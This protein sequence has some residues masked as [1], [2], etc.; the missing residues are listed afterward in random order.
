[1]L[2]TAVVMSL[3]SEPV[4]SHHVSFEQMDTGRGSFAKS[5]SEGVALAHDGHP[6]IVDGKETQDTVAAENIVM[7][8]EINIG[9]SIT[10]DVKATAAGKIEDELNWSALLIASGKTLG[11][12]T[13]GAVAAKLPQGSLSKSNVPI[14][15]QME[16]SSD[17]FSAG[18]TLATTQKAPSVVADASQMDTAEKTVAVQTGATTVAGLPLPSSG[19]SAVVLIPKEIEVADKTPKAPAAKAGRGQENVG[20]AGKVSKSEKSEKT[21][22]AEKAIGAASNLP[23]IEAQIQ[24]MT[25]VP[26]TVISMDTQPAK[27]NQTRE[28]AVD[29]S[30]STSGSTTMKRSSGLAGTMGTNG[31]ASTAIAKINAANVKEVVPDIQKSAAKP[32]PSKLEPDTATPQTASVPKGDAK[33]R[34]GSAAALAPALVRAEGGIVGVIPGVAVGNSSA[35]G[36]PAKERDSDLRSSAAATS[37]GTG[38]LVGPA[39]VDGGGPTDAMHRTLMASPTTLEVG[40]P[41]GT[42]GWL[43]IR[44]AMTDGGMVNASLSVASSSGQEMLHRELSSLTAYLQSERVA[45]NTVVVQPPAAAGMDSFGLAGGMSGNGREQSQQSGGQGGENRQSTA[46]AVLNRMEDGVPYNGLRGIA[47][48]ELLTSAPYLGGGSWLNVRA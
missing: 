3:G 26:G 12:G 27:V 42:H 4:N 18:N 6:A 47:G 48:D 21:D 31:G 35:N 33:G 17:Q 32:A 23:G 5:F 11:T 39:V 7:G 2:T 15:G 22:K 8:Q 41:D 28:N 40:V 1:M 37:N 13:G 10:P 38:I 43:K 14:D 45:V 29:S 44:A 34:D 19:Q 46:D 30:L 9:A 24:M 20:S 25:A 16:V 36:V